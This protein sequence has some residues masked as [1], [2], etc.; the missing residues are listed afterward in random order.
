MNV[1]FVLALVAQTLT[2][3][4]ATDTFEPVQEVI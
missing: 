3:I 4:Q 1:V 2:F